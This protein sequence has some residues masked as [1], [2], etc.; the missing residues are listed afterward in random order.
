MR[1]SQI[2]IERNQFFIIQF[3]N[4][5]PRHLRAQSMATGIGAGAHRGDELRGFP[6]LDEVKAR[7]HG[8]QLTGYAP[9]SN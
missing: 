7:S 3:P 4:G 6:F 1:L 2:L 9:P 8:P 5:T